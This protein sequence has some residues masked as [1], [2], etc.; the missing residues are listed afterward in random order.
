MDESKYQ[1]EEWAREEEVPSHST[2]AQED[3]DASIS[4]DPL[5]TNNNLTGNAKNE[6]G[7]LVNPEMPTSSALVVFDQ[8]F[9]EV[10]FNVREPAL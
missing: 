5:W 2:T 9:L 4:M 1:T 7:N 10:E 8:D 3:G 6:E